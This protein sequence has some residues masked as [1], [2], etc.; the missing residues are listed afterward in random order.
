MNTNQEQACDIIDGLIDEVRA[1]NGLFISLWHNETVSD[2]GLWE[3][4]RKVY[5]HLVQKAV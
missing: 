3:D 5:E 4:W 1:V 2:E